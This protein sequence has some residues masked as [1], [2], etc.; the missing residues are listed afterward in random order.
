M[1]VHAQSEQS[2]PDLLTGDGGRAVRF[3]GC[4]ARSPLPQPRVGGVG[5]G[6]AALGQSGRPWAACGMQ[7]FLTCFGHWVVLFLRSPWPCGGKMGCL[8][9][10]GIEDLVSKGTLVV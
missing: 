1:F 3:T 4:G 8:G 9:H 10:G 2:L 7:H 5:V 6:G